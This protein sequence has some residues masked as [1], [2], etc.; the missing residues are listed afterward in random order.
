M[1]DNELVWHT[2]G[3]K[4]RLRLNK[5]EVEIIET[6]CPNGNSGAC[7]HSRSGCLVQFFLTRYGFECN[8]GVCPIEEVLELCWSIA[9]DRNDPEAC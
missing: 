5:T 3:H 6:T 7:W 9:G 1:E 4:I 2:D 8:V